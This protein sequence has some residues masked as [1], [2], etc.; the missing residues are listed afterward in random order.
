MIDL[1][2]LLCIRD[3]KPVFNMNFDKLQEDQ[4]FEVVI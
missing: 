4:P 3:T 2:L 1:Y